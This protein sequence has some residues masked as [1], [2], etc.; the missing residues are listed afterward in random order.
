MTLEIDFPYGGNLKSILEAGMN[1]V[2]LATEPHYGNIY[3]LTFRGLSAQAQLHLKC[4]M[5]CL[6]SLHLPPTV[7]IYLFVVFRSPNFTYSQ[8]AWTK[9]TWLMLKQ[10]SLKLLLLLIK[11]YTIIT[12][13]KPLRRLIGS[14]YI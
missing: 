11:E 7:V 10:N 2:T 8:R 9:M 1:A 13:M 5:V 3:F 4:P 12:N 6:T 14:L